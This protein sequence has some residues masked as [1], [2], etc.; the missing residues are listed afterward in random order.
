MKIYCILLYCAAATIL[1]VKAAQRLKFPGKAW[2]EVGT[3]K[4]VSTSEAV[5]ASRAASGLTRYGYQST[6]RRSSGKL[7]LLED[8]DAT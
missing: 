3:P 1:D 7:C 8:C 4:A 6:D 5:C 2:A